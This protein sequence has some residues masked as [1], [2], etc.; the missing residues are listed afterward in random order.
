MP[1]YSGVYFSHYSSPAVANAN[2][3]ILCGQN[4]QAQNWAPIK[5][6]VTDYGAVNPGTN[7]YFRFP[8]IILPNTGVNNVPLTYKMKLLQY[9][10]GNAYPII[11][12]QFNYENLVSAVNSY[13][14][15]N[16]WAYLSYSNNV[17]QQTMSLSFNYNSAYFDI[18]YAN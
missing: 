3:R 15:N 1:F 8:L 10:N 14:F 4:T 9:S 18:Y 13:N 7:Y 16:E 12:S 2:T 5:L 11:L 17:V 6:T